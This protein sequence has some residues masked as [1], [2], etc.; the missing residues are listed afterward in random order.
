LRSTEKRERSNGQKVSNLKDDVQ[1]INAWPRP[2]TDQLVDPQKL[3][4]NHQ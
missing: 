4:H 3:D 2:D 1:E